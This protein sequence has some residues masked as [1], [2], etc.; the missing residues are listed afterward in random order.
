MKKDST[1]TTAIIF[2][3]IITASLTGCS[4]ND[5][6]IYSE[7]YYDGVNVTIDFGDVNISISDIRKIF[8]ELNISTNIIDNHAVGLNIQPTSQILFYEKYNDKIG[9][10]FEGYS[11]DDIQENLVFQ[12]L[13]SNETDFVTSSD[14]ANVSYSND[15]IIV[16]MYVVDIQN[17]FKS[18]FQI[19]PIN[20]DYKMTFYDKDGD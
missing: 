11:E 20:V 6:V 18:E 16:E 8:D 10:N 7:T 19:T 17:L 4:E 14:E 2:L 13:F 15:E 3:I 5:D 1:L 9:I 12:L